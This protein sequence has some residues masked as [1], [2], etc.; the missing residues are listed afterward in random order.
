MFK[1]ISQE[2][3]KRV[4]EESDRVL[5]LGDQTA[6]DFNSLDISSIPYENLKQLV[7]L[8]RY[9]VNEGVVYY[10][11][12]LLS[13]ILLYRTIFDNIYEQYTMGW[14]V[15]NCWERCTVREGVL[16]SGDDNRIAKKGE[17]LIFAPGQPHNPRGGKDMITNIDVEFSLT[18][19]LTS[20]K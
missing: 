8:K 16:I 19:F 5:S 15:H 17:V 14:Q 10:P 4:I 13:P 12:D 18:P 2:R 1:T 11:I 7:E 9:R 3:I 6:Y 20:N